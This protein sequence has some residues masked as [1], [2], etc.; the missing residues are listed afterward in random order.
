[1]RIQKIFTI[2]IMAI[3][4]FSYANTLTILGFTT[5]VN[6]SHGGNVFIGHELIDGGKW[7]DCG[8]EYHSDVRDCASMGSCRNDK[9]FSKLIDKN[10]DFK[11]GQYSNKLCV[12]SVQ[13]GSSISSKYNIQKILS[14][15]EVQFKLPEDKSL[16]DLCPSSVDITP[17]LNK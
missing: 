10:Q 2:T 12:V 9:V 14:V 5:G 15:K 11:C 17:Y 13:T 8:P 3:A 16:V 1:M 4:S 7:M 6:G